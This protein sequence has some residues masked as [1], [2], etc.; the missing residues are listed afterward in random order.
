MQANAGAVGAV[1]SERGG[2]L[3]SDAVAQPPDLCRGIVRGYPVAVS[4]DGEAV[5]AEPG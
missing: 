1:V 3:A 2:Q 5:S 4:V